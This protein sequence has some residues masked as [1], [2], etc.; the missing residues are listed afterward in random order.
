MK[1]IV[2]IGNSAAGISAAEIIRQ[3]DKDSKIIIVSNEDYL[4]YHR[5]LI[6]HYLAGD[7]KEERIIYRPKDFYS[8]NNIELIL[9]K[10]AQRIDVKKNQVIVED[11]ADRSQDK[12]KI[13]YDVL[14]LANGASSKFP[15]D[16]KGIQKNGVFGFR[17]IADAKQILELVPVAQVACVLGGG[18]VGLKAAYALKKKNLEVK[19][20]VRSPQI[21]SQVL[22]K[23]GAGLFERH[24]SENGI[25]ILTACDAQEI[26]GNGDVKAVKL[27]SGKVI[28]CSIVVVAKGVEPN[29]DLIKDSGINSEEGVLVDDY[30][31]TNI[32]NIYAAGD[33]A[34]TFDPILEK[35]QINALWP[36]AIEQGLLV[37]ENILSGNKKYIGS[38]GMNSVEFFG[39]PMISFGITN[40]KTDE[41][42]ELIYKDEKQN[43]YKKLVLKNNIIKGAIFVNRVENIGILLKL[44]KLKVDVSSL[45]DKLLEPSFNF[46]YVKDLGYEKDNI[47]L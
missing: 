43:I 3:K 25:D 32:P 28:A 36:N 29:I 8:G 16:L 26:I 44:A 24:L 23:Y 30:L 31:K 4:G 6:S 14:A 19:V 38:V 42:E 45:R 18:L 39:L 41:Y 12:I 1:R 9:N 11:L 15:K 22:D 17:T 21:L 47:Y 7:I 34:E 27:S 37:G 20:I 10:K 13:E 5:C 2:I 33:I 40:P 46:A 35:R